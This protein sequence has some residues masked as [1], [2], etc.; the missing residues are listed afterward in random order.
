LRAVGGLLLLFSALG[1]SLSVRQRAK[2]RE[3]ELSGLL[4]LLL[5]I[6]YGMLHGR[7]PLGEIYAAFQNEAL[8][9][10]GFLTR[11]REG[12]LFFALKADTLALDGEEL[13]FLLTYAEALG[14]RF[15]EEERKAS[16]EAQTALMSLCERHR[17]EGAK[18]SKLQG[19]L[20]VSGAGM[21][22]LLLL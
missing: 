22:L 10:S 13:A 19:T 4:D 20:L 16:E 12:G 17:T 1:A 8:T 14:K 11:L 9:S 6:R 15:L 5:A 3:A 2:R 18:K 7:L 21:L